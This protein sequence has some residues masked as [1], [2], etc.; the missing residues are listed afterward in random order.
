MQ[1]R[2]EKKGASERR[3]Y[4]DKTYVSGD[5]LSLRHMHGWQ[6]GAYFILSMKQSWLFSINIKIE[7]TAC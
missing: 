2:N 4:E 5:W 6:W 7:P 1:K 3:Y